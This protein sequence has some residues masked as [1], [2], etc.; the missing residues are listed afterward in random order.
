MK[1]WIVR[2]ERRLSAFANAIFFLSEHSA[3]LLAVDM[4][5]TI[6]AEYVQRKRKYYSIDCNSYKRHRL[7]DGNDLRS[8]SSTS[9]SSTPTEHTDNPSN[10]TGIHTSITSPTR[11]KWPRKWPINNLHNLL[12]EKAILY[13]ILNILA[14]YLFCWL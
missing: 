14:E 8:T 2:R 5:T 3:I 11:R 10:V 9:S 4:A 7:D 13:I 1:N 12:W 6:F